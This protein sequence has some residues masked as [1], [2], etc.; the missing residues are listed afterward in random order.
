MPLGITISRR[1]STSLRLRAN[2]A[3]SGDTATNA[4]TNRAASLPANRR[5][6]P[7]GL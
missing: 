4:S 6:P 5:V 2:A 1:A 7:R 3:V